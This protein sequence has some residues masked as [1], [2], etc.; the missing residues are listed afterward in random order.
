[1]NLSGPCNRDVA[2]LDVSNDTIPLIVVGLAR[3]HSPGVLAV[4]MNMRGD[5]LT[6]M[7][8]PDHDGRLTGFQN[9]RANWLAA[10]GPDMVFHME[11]S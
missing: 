9:Y 8:M 5:F 1:M 7:R 11:Y 10:R 4:R 2:R 6:R 3:N